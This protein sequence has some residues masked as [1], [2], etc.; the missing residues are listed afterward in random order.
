MTRRE[1]IGSLQNACA[2]I[3]AAAGSRV[4][5]TVEIH[6]LEQA[7]ADLRF[8]IA[9]PVKMVEERPRPKLTVIEKD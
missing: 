2:L 6:N 7:I 9:G 1:Y 4:F 8:V 5:S 3:Q